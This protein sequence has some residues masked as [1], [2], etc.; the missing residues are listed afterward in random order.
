MQSNIIEV[1]TRLGVYE[2]P[3]TPVAK[4]TRQLTSLPK[5]FTDEEKEFI[6]QVKIDMRIKRTSVLLEGCNMSRRLKLIVLPVL[7]EY[8]I[9]WEVLVSPSRKHNLKAPRREIWNLL[10]E[11]GLS[12]P[13]IAKLFNR[14]H[15][16]IIHGVN[17]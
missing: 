10:R 1:K 7:E 16:T 3:K 12:F 8:D 4:I 2:K 5:P 13:Q 9:P 17:Q 14:D 15:T 6:E 11:D